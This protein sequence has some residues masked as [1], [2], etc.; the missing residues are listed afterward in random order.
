MTS[1]IKVLGMTCISCEKR[2]EEAIQALSSV[3][4]IKADHRR[5]R[6][7]F[8]HV[9]EPQNTAEEASRNQAL[10]QELEAAINK[11]GYRY[12]GF[13]AA[14]QGSPWPSV[15]LSAL[16]ITSFLILNSLGIFNFLPRVD[17][18]LGLGLVFV[19]GLLTSVHCVAMCGGIALSQHGRSKAA[20]PRHPGSQADAPPTETTGSGAL[21]SRAGNGTLLYHLGRIV[22]YTLLG[23]LVGGLGS[24]LDFSLGTKSLLVAIASVFMMVMGLRMLGLFKGF[25]LPGL[26]RLSRLFPPRLVAGLRA[27]GPFF[28]GLLNG[29]MPCGPL[30][31]MQLYALGTGS[32]FLGAA[33]MFLF[34]LGTV[35]LLFLFTAL[36]GFFTKTW[37][38][39]IMQASAVMVVFFGLVMAGRA[40]EL[41]GASGMLQTAYQKMTGSGTNLAARPATAGN[42]APG[43]STSLAESL[44]LAGSGPNRSAGGAAT[45]RLV[46]G[47]QEVS[48]DL[49]ASQY[50][51]ITVQ[52]GIPVRWTI[53][54]D[55]RNINGCNEELVVPQYNI[56]KKLVPGANV[57]TFTPDDSGIVN[58]SCWMGMISSTIKVV[59][60]LPAVP[61]SSTLGVPSTSLGPLLAT[62]KPSVAK[63]VLKNEG[64]TSV[65]E[66]L[67]SVNAGGYSP[68]HVVVQRGLS[69]RFVFNVEELTGCNR[70]VEFPA[71]GGGLDL[72]KSTRTPLLPVESDFVFHCGMNMLQAKV[73]VVDSLEKADLQG[74]NIKQSASQAACCGQ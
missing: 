10:S 50:A 28:V 12:A 22:S 64:G 7:S 20:R 32:V 45:A 36:S 39:R 26:P 35:P 14:D 53:N 60:L 23:A 33:S 52:K 4:A 5:G 18:S 31:T 51:P 16:L 55:E 17:S 9:P 70:I 49:G 68:Q 66:V 21:R 11:A 2:V 1:I 27:R 13:V 63:A 41:S 73:Q 42:T 62:T 40:L 25:R 24:V 59:D 72:A 65:Q 58:Y 3:S 69:A 29:L 74:M 6:V 8:T 34:S 71:Y 48:F 61:E 15:L 44:E 46:D 47:V 19:A 54:A 57:I 38:F 67:I 30:Q 43:T 37:N 56:R